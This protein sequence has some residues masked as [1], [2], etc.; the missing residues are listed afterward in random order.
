MEDVEHEHLNEVYE[1]VP[2]EYWDE[3]YRTNLIQRL[4]HVLRFRAVRRMLA[5]LPQGGKILDVGCG[6][7]FAAEHCATGRPDLRV[8]GVDVAPALIEY[9]RK[10]RPQFHFE[11]APGEALPFPDESFDAVL[12]LDTIEHL[13]HPARALAEARRV[14]KKNG[15]LIILVVL[16]HHPV[17][18]VIWWLWMRLKGK[19]WHGA[20]LRVFSKKYLRSLVADAG[21]TIVKE[22]NLFAGMSVLLKARK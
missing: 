20:H 1:Q 19:V 16:E 2:P 14:L 10:K 17:F 9:A 11:T 18:R 4:Y 12:S 3:S 21:F 6:S 15:S 13:V 7:G 5:D 22:Q 8:S